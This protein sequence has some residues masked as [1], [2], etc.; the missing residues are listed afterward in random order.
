V[1]RLLLNVRFLCIIVVEMEEIRIKQP[2]RSHGHGGPGLGQSTG[3]SVQSKG[4]PFGNLITNQI[5]F[6]FYTVTHLCLPGLE[7]LIGIDQVFVHQEVNMSERKN[8]H[9]SSNRISSTFGLI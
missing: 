5:P 8:A 2:Q 4:W 6:L 3:P 7:F 9:N 1:S